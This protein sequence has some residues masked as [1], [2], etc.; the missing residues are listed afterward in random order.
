MNSIDQFIGI[1]IYLYSVMLILYK[2]STNFKVN[3]PF[4]QNDSI[5]PVECWTSVA[6]TE[7]N[8]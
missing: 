5:E 2:H 1:F 6:Q 4:S 8:I 7:L 3:F